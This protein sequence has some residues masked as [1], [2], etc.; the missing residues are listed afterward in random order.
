MLK[1]FSRLL[2]WEPKHRLPY[3]GW[4]WKNGCLTHSHEDGLTLEILGTPESHSIS[5]SGHVNFDSPK[6]SLHSKILERVSM[7]FAPYQDHPPAT[8][9]FD[10]P[11]LRVILTLSYLEN[12][13]SHHRQPGYA[14]PFHT[15]ASDHPNQTTIDPMLLRATFPA[16]T[17]SLRP[18]PSPIL[19]TNDP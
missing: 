4:K 15:P 13:R 12:A 8:Y 6:S 11:Q 16:F 1:D 14:L 18:M 5:Y 7:D 19:S 2:L 9:V 17:I 3:E 10:R